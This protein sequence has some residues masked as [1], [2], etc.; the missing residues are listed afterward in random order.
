M[1]Q[2]TPAQLNVIR[3]WTEERDS[4]R[5]EIGTL[6]TERD[7]LRQ[8]ADD[9]LNALNDINNRI[10][11]A[12]GRILELEALEERHRTSVATDVAELEARK[13]RLEAECVAKEAESDSWDIRIAE[14]FATSKM[15]TL[16]HDKMSDQATIVDQVVEQVIETS[17]KAVSDMKGDMAEVR[18]VVLEVI[19]KGNENVKQTNVVIEGLPKFIFDMQKPIP[20]RRK[21]PKGHPYHENDTPL[22]VIQEG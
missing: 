6:S 15:L 18:A 10:A 19:E 20:V 17:K 14:K 16:V 5:Q 9:G 2:L 22:T 11:K 21:Y 8:A 12:R 13:S 1:N 4:L 3:T 7:N